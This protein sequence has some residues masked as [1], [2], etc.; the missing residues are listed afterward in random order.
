MKPVELFTK[1]VIRLPNT[2]NEPIPDAIDDDTNEPMHLDKQEKNKNIENNLNVDTEENNITTSL[3]TDETP[4]DTLDKNDNSQ[5]LEINVDTN[6]SMEPENNNN[7]DSSVLENID[8]N[9]SIEPEN[10]ENKEISI[11]TVV[12]HTDNNELQEFKID[13]D[14]FTI[15]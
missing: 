8:T 11:D 2:L 14:D 3:V 15:D 4:I 9:V 5:N 13:L 10:N 7:P 1:C 6:G 12:E